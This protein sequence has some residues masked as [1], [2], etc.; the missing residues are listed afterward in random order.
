MTE[1]PCCVRH[2]WWK[3]PV[4]LF[5]YH[6]SLP[7]HKQY[8]SSEQ[9]EFFRKVIVML[10]QAYTLS[11][12][13]PVFSCAFRCSLPVISDMKLNTTRKERTFSGLSREHFKC[14]F[15]KKDHVLHG[16]PHALRLSLE[17][18]L[19]NVACSGGVT[20]LAPPMCSLRQA[21]N[22]AL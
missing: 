18:V 11:S 19:W 2:G 12:L 10:C 17:L 16:L 7:S 14:S 15:S 1:Q 22:C 9:S 3:L 20:A 8:T 4:F 21:G 6:H 5:V 13:V